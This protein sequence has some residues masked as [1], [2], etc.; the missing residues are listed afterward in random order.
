MGAPEEYEI[1][2][3]DQQRDELRQHREGQAEGDEP[4]ATLRADVGRDRRQ[5]EEE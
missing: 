1:G 2:R 5:E 3:D 4:E